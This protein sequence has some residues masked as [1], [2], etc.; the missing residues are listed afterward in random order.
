M[1]IR[2]SLGFRDWRQE[3]QQLS[4][5][6]YISVFGTLMCGGGNGAQHNRHEGYRLEIV[7]QIP[8]CVYP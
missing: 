8:A 7:R 6:S 4:P 2:P 3:I 5:V 1:H